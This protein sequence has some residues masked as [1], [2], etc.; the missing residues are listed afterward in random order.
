MVSVEENGTMHR[1]RGHGLVQEVFN[2]ER[3]SKLDGN[4]CLGH[5]L[6]TTAGG[7]SVDNIEPLSFLH[8]TGSFA[9]AH[10]GNIVNAQ[11]IRDYLALTPWKESYDQPR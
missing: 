10:N 8:N 6:Y 7:R 4:M 2:E 3:L 1:H 11:Q 5:L 9:I